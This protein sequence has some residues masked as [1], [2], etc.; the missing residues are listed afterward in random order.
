MSKM[1]Y[2][3]L[4]NDLSP[5]K[6]FLDTALMVAAL[7]SERRPE[8]PGYGLFKLGEASLVDLYTSEDALREAEGVLRSLLGAKAEHVKLLLAESL[9]FGNVAV[10]APPSESTVQE[11]IAITRYRADAIILAAA[12]E[13]D[14]EVFVTYDK[15]HLL[16]NPLIGPP[17]TRIVVM[18]GGEA[19]SWAIDQISVRSRLKAQMRQNG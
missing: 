11:C 9:A 2:W 15:Q 1:E 19:K 13:R 18:T 12:I 17:N 5:P 8:S 14:C 7:I 6:L 10:T 16:N 3:R 4:M